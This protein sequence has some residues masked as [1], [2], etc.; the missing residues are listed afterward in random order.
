MEHRRRRFP[1]ISF[2]KY[3]STQIRAERIQ[4][5]N[6]PQSALRTQRRARDFLDRR[7]RAIRH[8]LTQICT[9]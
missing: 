2:L 3:N 6:L 7:A 5:L 9:D 8:G 1:Q 4:D